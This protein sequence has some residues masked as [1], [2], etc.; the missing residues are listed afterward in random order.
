MSNYFLWND[1]KSTEYGCVMTA[2]PNIV[3][4]KERVTFQSV[5]GRSGT[6]ALLE[7]EYVY[8]D[9]T[10]DL[11]CYVQDLKNITAIANWLRGYGKLVLPSTGKAY[12]GRLANQI[13]ITQIVRGR[14]NRN[15]TITMRCEPFAYDSVSNVHTF[16]E[17]GAETIYYHGTAPARPKFIVTATGDYDLTINGSVIN[18]SSPDGQSSTASGII[19]DSELME[20]TELDGTTL[21]NTRVIMDEFPVIM[22]GTYIDVGWAEGNAVSSVIIEERGRDI[23]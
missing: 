23:V 16:T 11:R 1:K 17:S 14:K 2:E 3:I 10:I 4:P 6:L 9:I 5:P 19:I 13:S 7:G 12:Y 15:F 21:A 22:P 18:V 8:D 20:C